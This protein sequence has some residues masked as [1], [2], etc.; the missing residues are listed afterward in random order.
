VRAVVVRRVL[1]LQPIANDADYPAG[2]YGSSGSKAPSAR[3]STKSVRVPQIN[4]F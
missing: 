4:G 2:D 1:P 3:R